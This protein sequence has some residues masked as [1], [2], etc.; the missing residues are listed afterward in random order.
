MGLKEDLRIGIIAEG[1]SDA[2]VLTNILRGLLKVDKSQFKYIRPDVY[3]DETDLNTDAEKEK[4]KEKE[5]SNWT[6]VK[7]ECIDKTEI[8]KFL[9]S[10]F[11][12]ERILII[13][14]DTDVRNLEGYEV[15]EPKKSKSKKYSEALRANVIL[16]INEWLDESFEDIFYAITIEETEAW[17]LTLIDK[18]NNDTDFY[19][20]VKERYFKYINRNATKKMKNVLKNKDAFI[21]YGS[22]SQP[23][24]KLKELTKARSKN[25]SLDLFCYSLNEHFTEH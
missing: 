8:D 22:L 19:L 24:S 15:F 12:E 5:F 21:K 13:Q 6:L 25:R 17:L 2:A 7:K 11:E 18:S 16:K 10:P 20:K 4:D 1:K 3:K 23:L 9:N 14:I